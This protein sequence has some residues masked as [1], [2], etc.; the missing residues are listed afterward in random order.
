M[1]TSLGLQAVPPW[2]EGISC[3]L[4]NP[5]LGCQDPKIHSAV[6]QARF[7]ARLRSAGKTI[8]WPCPSLPYRD[9]TP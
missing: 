1:D 2:R 8:L 7:R 3:G 4:L 5:D 9:T 6:T